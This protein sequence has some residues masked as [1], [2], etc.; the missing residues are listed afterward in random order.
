MH[1]QESSRLGGGPIAARIVLQI[2]L[3]APACPLH[4]YC[5]LYFAPANQEEDLLYLVNGLLER[6]I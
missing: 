4:A 6:R 2:P 5:C 1:A 3:D